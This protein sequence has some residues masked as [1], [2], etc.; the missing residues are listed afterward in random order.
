MKWNGTAYYYV[1]NLQGDIIGILDSDG[2]QVV[3]YV[4]E[5]WGQHSGSYEAWLLPLENSILSGTGGITSIKNRGFT[6]LIPG[7]MIPRLVDSS[8]RI[9]TLRVDM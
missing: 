7:T 9:S 3:E 6:I 8:M 2:N 1:K 4:Y 5:T